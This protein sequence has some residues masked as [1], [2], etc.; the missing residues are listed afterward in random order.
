MGPAPVDESPV[1]GWNRPE[2]TRVSNEHNVKLLW[3]TTSVTANFSPTMSHTPVVYHE[4]HDARDVADAYLD[5]NEVLCER[6]S[7]WSIYH[8]ILG[9][10]YSDDLTDALRDALEDR[11]MW[12]Y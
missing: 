10:G 11:G 7:G 4:T 5:A 12:R 2:A 6:T 8:T 1:T 9:E 3:P